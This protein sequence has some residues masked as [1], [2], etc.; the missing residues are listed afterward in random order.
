MFQDMRADGV[1]ERPILERQVMGI[2]NNERAINHQVAAALAIIC[3][4]I[5]VEQHIGAGVRIVAAPDL[6]D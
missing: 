3:A 6:K 2:C 1:G 4:R 5:A